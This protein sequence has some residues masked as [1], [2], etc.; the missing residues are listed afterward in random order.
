LASKLPLTFKA[1]TT[2]KETSMNRTVVIALLGIVG[3]VAIMGCGQGG[4][5]GGGGGE[6]TYQIT[7]KQLQTF[8]DI[9]ALT[10]RQRDAVENHQRFGGE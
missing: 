5:G 8:E 2:G 6:R 1:C 7:E 3:F 10:Q 4:G 9:S